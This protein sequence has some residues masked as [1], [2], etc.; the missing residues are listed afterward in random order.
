MKSDALRL[1]Q[2]LKVVVH[3]Y[4]NMSGMVRTYGKG[5]IDFGMF[6]REFNMSLPLFA[7]IDAGNGK[8]CADAKLRGVL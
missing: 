2:N 7:F 5:P 8:E 1:H 6:V 4:V 3:I